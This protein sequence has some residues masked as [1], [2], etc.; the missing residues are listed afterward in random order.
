MAAPE[1]GINIV[2]WTKAD[3]DPQLLRDALLSLQKRVSNTAAVAAF[4]N[5]GKPQ[6]VLMYT[7]DLVQAGRNAGADIRVGAQFIQGGG[8]G[9][10]GIASAGGKNIAGLGQAL[11]AI[12]KHITK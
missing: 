7:P 6:L 12:V 10:P 11:D 2:R 3:T 9:Q 5:A 1:G 4:E 8:G